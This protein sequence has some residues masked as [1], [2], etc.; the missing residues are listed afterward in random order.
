M[1]KSMIYFYYVVVIISNYIDI[2]ASH[3]KVITYFVDKIIFKM[4]QIS[5]VEIRQACKEETQTNQLHV[6]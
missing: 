2:D 4:E 5:G 3:Q 6:N 1:K